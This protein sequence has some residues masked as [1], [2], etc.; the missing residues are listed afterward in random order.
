MVTCP[1]GSPMRPQ[2]GAQ[3]GAQQT[4]S[5]MGKKMSRV[6]G[7]FQVKVKDSSRTFHYLPRPPPHFFSD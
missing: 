2:H 4:C 6:E 1:Q 5:R 3:R 7:L